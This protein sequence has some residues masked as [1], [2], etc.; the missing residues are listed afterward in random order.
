MALNEVLRTSGDIRRFLAQTM[1]EIRS[2]DLSID[3]GMTIAA[4]SKEITANMQTEVN[5]AKVRVQ[6]LATGENMGDVTQMGKLVIEDEGS[7]PMLS[8]K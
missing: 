5:V 7:T 6:M 1:S 8:G 3:K 4:L 2:G